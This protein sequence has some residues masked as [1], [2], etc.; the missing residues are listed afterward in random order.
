MRLTKI[1]KKSPNLNW[2]S[3]CDPV[4]P[5]F[6]AFCELPPGTHH[7]TLGVR[8]RQRANKHTDP[9]VM[10]C[11]IAPILVLQ[12]LLN[13]ITHWSD[14]M[15]AL[16]DSVCVQRGAF[17]AALLRNFCLKRA[18]ETP[19][20]YEGCYHMDSSLVSTVSLKC[21]HSCFYTASQLFFLE[22][23]LSVSVWHL[24][25]FFCRSQLQEEHLAQLLPSYREQER[26]RILTP[27]TQ[28]ASC[29]PLSQRR[30]WKRWGENTRSSIQ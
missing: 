29:W 13:E 1:E 17:V 2:S 14:F 27:M 23:R 10:T 19:P 11:T 3:L 26:R 25:V 9:S 22:S 28:K 21:L 30:R 4:I 5:P 18:C 8:A 15:Q 7:H 16:F 20:V 6:W 12:S 24:P